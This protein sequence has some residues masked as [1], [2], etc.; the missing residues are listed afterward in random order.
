[1]EKVTRCRDGCFACPAVTNL[2]ILGLLRKHRGAHGHELWDRIS[3][4]FSREISVT[5]CGTKCMRK[6]FSMVIKE[7]HI[8]E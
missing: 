3:F 4:S 8:D 1:M 6:Y 7:V 5:K 2:Q